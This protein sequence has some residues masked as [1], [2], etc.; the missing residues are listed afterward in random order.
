M[1]P[2]ITQN[3]QNEYR[4]GQIVVGGMTA[5]RGML[6][7]PHGADRTIIH[8]SLLLVRSLTK[9]LLLLPPNLVKLLLEV[10]AEPH[11]IFHW[12]YRVSVCLRDDH[13]LRDTRHFQMIGSPGDENTLAQYHQ[14][15]DGGI[16]I[17]AKG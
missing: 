12:T 11:L 2:Q 13:N 6:A 7:N 15:M 4:R 14:I 10:S 1:E 5:M 17:S 3:T 16:Q 9:V 8:V